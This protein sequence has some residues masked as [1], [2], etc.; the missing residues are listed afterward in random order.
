[1]HGH[2]GLVCGRRRVRSGDRPDAIEHPDRKEILVLTYVSREAAWV[3]A[4]SI[5]RYEDRPP[6]LGRWGPAAEGLDAIGRFV[7]AM[8]LGVG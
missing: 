4:A 6:R 8:R 2:L 5:T 3:E 1:M 7:N